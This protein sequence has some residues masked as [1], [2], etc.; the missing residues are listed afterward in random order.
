MITTRFRIAGVASMCQLM[1]IENG[2]DHIDTAISSFAWGTSHPGTESMVALT[3]KS[4][5]RSTPN[6]LP[7]A[8]RD[9]AT[10]S[11]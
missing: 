1:A 8:E 7:S 10:P 2:A 3:R 4:A 6:V 9:S 5:S 11:V